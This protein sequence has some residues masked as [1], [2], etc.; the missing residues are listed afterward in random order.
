MVDVLGRRDLLHGAVAQHGHAV[1]HAHRLDLVVRDVH[2]RAVEIALQVL[3]LAAHLEPQQRV[4]RRERLVEE[5]RARVAHDRAADR[6]ALALAARELRGLA[7][8]QRLDLQH[9]GRPLHA[10]A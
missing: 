7:V 1:G 10:L 5:V 9:L 8:E 2:E 6:D 4:E 3:E